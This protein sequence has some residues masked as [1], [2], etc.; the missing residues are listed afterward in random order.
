M[1]TKKITKDEFQAYENVRASGVTN[2]FA[3]GTVCE[4]SG[5]E[6]DKVMAIM[7]Q[8]TELNKLY[9]DVRNDDVEDCERCGTPLEGEKG[10]LCAVCKEE[11][12]EEE[13][14]SKNWK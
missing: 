13:E 2:M 12:E 10:N 14:I 3:V 11:I 8:Y 1:E 5:L 7:S 4:L 6:K 9:P